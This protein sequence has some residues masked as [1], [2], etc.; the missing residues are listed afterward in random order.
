[1]NEKEE[2]LEKIESLI[3]SA[4]K[5]NEMSFRLVLEGLVNKG[6]EEAEYLLV[7]YISSK[8]LD[9][10]T[11]INII[12]VVGYVQSTHFLIPL[13]KV[14]DIED[15]IHLKKEAVISVSK[16][17]DR[18][19]LNILNY[20][21]SNIKNTLL[22]ET[23]NNEISKIKR[24][25]P[26]FALLPRFLDGEK[27]PKNFEVTLGILK[28]ILTP[29]DAAMFASYLNCGKSV[30]EKGAFEILC[31]AADMEQ[32]PVILRFFQDQFNQLSCIGEP[33]CEALYTMTITLKRY[34]LRFPSLIEGNL[35]NLGTQLYY[36]HD[37]RIRGLFISILCQSQQPP[38][39]AF[40]NKVYDSDSALRDSIIMEYSGNEAAADLLFDKYRSDE[41]LLKG[42]LIKSLLNT[43]KGIAY[44][45]ENFF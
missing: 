1:M 35:D 5:F 21:L 43:K 30:I 29:N 24:N 15:N 14:I 33:E 10:Q 8:E 42:L 31:Y 12:R 22:L 6:G 9:T 26:V 32:Q 20:A 17:N 23:I 27:N 2:L 25:N 40:V 3:Y 44:F 38:A 18:R 11:R 36:V 34:F 7:R 45:Y 37:R 4:D 16:Y 13:K 41:G 39:I 19:A 28:R